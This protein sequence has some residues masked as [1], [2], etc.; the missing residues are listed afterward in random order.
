MRTLA[1]DELK[2]VEAKL[3]AYMGD[4]VEAFLQN[5][6]LLHRCRV[7]VVPEL[8]Y[9]YSSMIPR[10]KMLTMGTCLG[11]FTKTKKFRLQITGLNYLAYYTNNKVWVKQNAEM[12][13]L[14]GNHLIKR[15]IQKVQLT[16]NA[17]EGDNHVGCVIY[18]TINDVPL[19]FGIINKN[20]N[21]VKNT[22]AIVAYNQGDNGLY[23][24]QE[25]EIFG[26]STPNDLRE[27]DNE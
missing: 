4:N 17:G 1:K 15:H 8:V 18:S 3:K 16:P 22:D 13:F 25:K 6:L 26:L 7:F 10:S 20:Y 24:R 19:G 9:R 23:V 12:S 21:Q 14:Y 2:V 11:K 5:R 27:H